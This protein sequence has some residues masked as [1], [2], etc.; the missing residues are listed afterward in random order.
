[1]VVHISYDADPLRVYS[2]SVGHGG[3]GGYN[4]PF[5]QILSEKNFFLSEANVAFGCGDPLLHSTAVLPPL[6]SAARLRE[7]QEME[8]GWIPFMTVGTR[9]TKFYVGI[10]IWLH[11]QTVPK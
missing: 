4:C 10:S 5:A 9:A 11:L 7:A 1:M 8:E 3:H 2:L 6:H